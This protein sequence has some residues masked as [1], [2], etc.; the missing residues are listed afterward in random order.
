MHADNW[1]LHWSE[2]AASAEANPAQRYRRRLI[3]ACLTASGS[4]PQR[5]IDLG[6][7]QGDLAG[8]LVQA[9]P[10]AS[11]L[12]LELS[13][14]GVRMSARKVPG[15][16]FLQQDL[17]QKPSGTNP[18]RGWAGHAVCSEVLEH[19]DNPVS[20]LT[21][22]RD[23]MAPGCSLIVTVPGGPMSAFDRHIGHRR[24]Y[25]PADL[26]AMLDAAG[27]TVCAAHAAG[28]PFFNLY[29]LTV[30]LRGKALINDVSTRPGFLP[31]LASRTLMGIFRA[32]FLLNTTTTSRG[33]QTI[34]V[35]RYEKSFT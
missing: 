28:Y 12:G 33:W 4:S 25:S 6:S 23:F 29:R 35:A 20:F 24:H 27:F 11:V 10:S 34:A 13:E 2:Y 7:G 21:N 15:A 18:Y 14:A 1:D 19:L 26:S 3:R 5:I 22:A 30:I 9:F 8:E 31:R 17:L 16:S 32:L